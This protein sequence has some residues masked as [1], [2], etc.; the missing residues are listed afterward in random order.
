[1][2]SAPPKPHTF[3]LTNFFSTG[4]L[5][6][7]MTSQIFAFSQIIFWQIAIK[8][9]IFQG[10]KSFQNIKGPPCEYLRLTGGADP[11]RSRLVSH[12]SRTARRSCFLVTA[13]LFK[14]ESNIRVFFWAEDELFK[15]LRH[16]ITGQFQ[17]FRN[18][19][20]RTRTKPTI[21]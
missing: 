16:Q 7:L 10:A 2:L 4:I 5:T 1:M 20:P 13:V 21:C 9:R 14:K 19:S 12:Y 17:V 6:D 18:N 15:P 3:L 8:Y 11:G